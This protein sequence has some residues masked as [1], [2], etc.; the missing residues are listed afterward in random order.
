MEIHEHYQD[1]V[2]VLRI[3]GQVDSMSGPELGEKLDAVVCKGHVHLVLDLSEV[4][5]MSSA[6]LRVLS[7]ALKTVRASDPGGD[8]CLAGL[9]KAVAHAFRISGFNQVFSIYDGVPEAVAVLAASRDV[10]LS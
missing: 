3:S 8:I 4:P 1:G 10:D 7:V 5:Y 9:S 2:L 6:G